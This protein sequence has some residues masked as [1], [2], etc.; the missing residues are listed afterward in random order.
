MHC[1]LDHC[2]YSCTICV[3][4]NQLKDKNNAHLNLNDYIR[5]IF[6]RW[7]ATVRSHHHHNDRGRFQLLIVYLYWAYFS[8]IMVNC[9][10][11][12]ET[13]GYI[14][15]WV[16]HKRIWSSTFVFVFSLEDNENE[17]TIP[18]NNFSIQFLFYVLQLTILN[19]NNLHTV[20]CFQ[21]F[22]SNINNSI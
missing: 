6:L 19:T 7:I 21:V 14:L 13:L 15:Y 1:L 8:C 12:L 4:V 16:F 11:L 18:R 2:V 17:K 20:K 22:Q 5:H 3:S 10:V 9:E